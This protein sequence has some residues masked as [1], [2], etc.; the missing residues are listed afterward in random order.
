[1]IK[2]R[3]LTQKE[4]EMKEFV[5]RHRK[6]SGKPIK[7]IEIKY[8]SDILDSLVEHGVLTD[9]ETVNGR[10]VPKLEKPSKRNYFIK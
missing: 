10:S 3:E 4:K 6:A 1:M 9:Y 2:Q 7:P 8:E 5:E